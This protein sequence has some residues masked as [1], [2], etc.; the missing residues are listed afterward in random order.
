[1]HMHAVVPVVEQVGRVA[2][3]SVVLIGLHARQVR[4]VPSQM[5]VRP[6]QS[7]FEVHMVPEET[8][9][10]TA[11]AAGPTEVP[12]PTLAALTVCMPGVRLIVGVYS[13]LPDESV[14]AV[15]T[16]MPSM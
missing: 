16:R 1:M 10:P 12:G 2:V 11:M 14:V 6:E 15:P 3:Q 9:N 5:G 4:V 13:K 7:E 8:V